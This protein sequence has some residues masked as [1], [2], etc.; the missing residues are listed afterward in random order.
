[1]ER[2]VVSMGT[3]GV[4]R[5]RFSFG[6]SFSSI[7]HRTVWVVLYGTQGIDLVGRDISGPHFGKGY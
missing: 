6:R 5:L 1:M 2:T 4:F 3:V 7:D